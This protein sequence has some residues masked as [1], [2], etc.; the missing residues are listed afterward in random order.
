MHFPKN[1]MLV[2][3]NDMKLNCGNV[4]LFIFKCLQVV[5]LAHTVLVNSPCRVIE[6]V[7]TS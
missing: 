1:R 4:T 6:T 7:P 3:L 2:P 5:T